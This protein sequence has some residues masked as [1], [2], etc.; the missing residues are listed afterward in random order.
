MGHDP[1]GCPCK[2][3]C[4]LAPSQPLLWDTTFHPHRIASCVVIVWRSR[5]LHHATLRTITIQSK[6]AR[7][8]ARA[9][10]KGLTT[11]RDCN[12]IARAR[13]SRRRVVS[14]GNVAPACRTRAARTTLL[15][16]I[17]F[18]RGGSRAPMRARRRVVSHGNVAPACPR[19]AARTTLPRDIPF[20]RASLTMRLEF[21]GPPSRKR[22][23][24][25]H[26]RS[27]QIVPKTPN[28]SCVGLDCRCVHAVAWCH[29]A[30]CLP[31]CRTGHSAKHTGA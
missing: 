12:P 5:G 20:R 11:P 10:R 21:S 24:F 7:A 3:G 18:R 29:T 9:K 17:Q 31:T 30:I 22:L 27:L 13:H 16:D 14:Q 28:T 8:R 6:R 4:N 19:R 15:C 23:A 26:S 2:S 25:F 1:T